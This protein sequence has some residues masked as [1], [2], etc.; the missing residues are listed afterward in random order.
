MPTLITAPPDGGNI[1]VLAGDDPEALRLRPR[2]DVAAPF[3]Q[4]FAA[5]IATRPGTV[6]VSLED[7]AGSSYPAGW[8]DYRPCVSLDGE[9]WRR[10][11]AT[12]EEGT[13]RFAAEAPDGVLYVA[14]FA[15]Y[16]AARAQHFTA[17]CAASPLAAYAPLGLS[18]KG[19]P[20]ERLTIGEGPRT[21]WVIA[22]QHPGET[23]GSWW[24]EGFL[25]K[26]LDAGDE[27]AGVLRAGATVHVVPMMNPDGV[28]AGN[29]RTNAVGTDINRAWAEPSEEDS[30][31]VLAVRSAMEDTGCDLFL[32]VHG[33]EAIANN[34]I[35]GAKGI[36]GWTD[37]L[38]GLQD[39]YEA[40]LVRITP[41]FQ[42]E[43]GYPIPAPGTANPK[44]ATNWV[45]QRFDCL[46]MTL[47]MPFKDAKSN[48]KPDE[49]WSPDR[50][51]QLGRSCLRAMNE[52]AASLR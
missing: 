8:R 48:P 27:D 26:L 19:Q 7:L 41:D 17:R 49:G 32:D 29:L 44:I 40:A 46:S 18:A 24:M 6:H 13:L 20:I 30:P 42:R 36:P 12:Y 39:A 3:R 25:P 45:A 11:P 23:M 5:R 2:D 51:R 43:E 1:T 33:D 4:Y 14:Y 15:P 47:E 37:R 31:E 9:T 35:A 50:C 21:L 28:A 10:V 34:F 16:G 22:R 52:V 38:E